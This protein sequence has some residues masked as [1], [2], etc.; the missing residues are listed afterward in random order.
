MPDFARRF[1]YELFALALS[2]LAAVAHVTLMGTSPESRAAPSLWVRAL[3]RAEGVATDLKFKLRGERKYHPDVVVATVDERGAQKFGRWPWKRS[4]LARAI[5]NLRDQGAKT[6]ALDI[7]F[8]DQ[9]DGEGNAFAALLQ[10]FGDFAGADAGPMAQLL[11]MLGQGGALGE[12]RA[13]AAALADAGPALV[14]GVMALDAHAAKDFSPEKLEADLALLEPHLIRQLPG[15]TPPAK[16]EADRLPGWEHQAVQMP[17]PSFA[18]AGTRFGNIGAVLDGDG[19]VRRT[20]PFVRLTEAKALLPSLGLEAAA[21]F[22]DAELKPW[23]EDLELLG[24]QLKGSRGEHRIPLRPEDPF[25][26][27][28]YPGPGAS[29]AHVSLSD[30]I[31]GTLPNG[32]VEGKLVLVGVTLTGSSGDQRVTPFSSL[33]PGVYT[34][35]AF[36]SNV[37]DQRFLTR[38]PWLEGGELL[39]MI[40]LSLVLA[41]FVP[42]LQRFTL[43]AAVIVA[44]LVAW[45]AVDQWL[46]S[47]GL[48][49][50]TAVPLG[51]LVLVSFGVVFL[52]YRSENSEKRAQRKTFERYLGVEVLEEALLHPEKLD[53]GEKREL[54]VLFSDIRGFTSLAE[55]MS[56]DELA[57]FIN[58]YL[59][60]MTRIVFEEKGTLDKYIGDAIMAFWNAPIEQ[61]DHAL[62]ACRAA[63]AMLTRLESLKASWRAKGFP[64]FDIGIGI[65]TG[66]MIVGNMG[67]D[68][69]VEYTVMGDAVNLASRLES[70]NKEYDT[71]VILGAGTWAQV[72]GQVT[73]RR[74]GAVR[75]KGKREPAQIYELRAIGAPGPGDAEAIRAF[76]EALIAYSVQDW[77]TA[78]AG[79]EKALAAWPNDGPSRRYLAEIELF[80]KT[81]PGPDWDGVYAASTK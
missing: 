7:T 46:F 11:E 12:D 21:A 50:W 20:A 49:A 35:A 22:L 80:E 64:E 79:F 33:E 6:I 69:R 27:I 74:L 8:T 9:V 72:K 67:S 32:A 31:E 71:R 28:D 4:L 39:A 18:Q 40:A 38:P 76:E 13:L 62:R 57:R 63:M 19:A 37:L 3:L 61:A 5:E 10:Q 14:Q 59:S 25:V 51:N 66:P 2:C 77:G 24:V 78:R 58:E 45:V 29:A 81:P 65:N 68:V 1:R 47:L 54:T 75:V 15:V 44:A 53:R 55:R 34:H 23:V 42:R 73:G 60:P 56:P 30:A 16:F 36:L 48:L 17:L 52:G 26:L 70:T 43:K 41:V